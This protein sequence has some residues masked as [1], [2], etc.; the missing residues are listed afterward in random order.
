MTDILRKEVMPGNELWQLLMLLAMV[1]VAMVAGQLARFFI[2]RA[3]ARRKTESGRWMLVLLRSL[4]RAIILICF[5]VGL[6]MGFAY[7]TVTPSIRSVIDTVL[8][9]LGTIAVGYLIYCLVDLVD[10]FLV[11]WTAKTG[12]KVDSMLLPLVGKSVRI[13]IV[14]L[15][16]VQ[17]L[18]SISDKPITSILAGLGVGGLALALAGQETLKNVIGSLVIVADKP[19]EIGDRIKVGEFDGPV[20]SVG[21]RSTR[22]RTI[23]G[24]LVTIPNS[25]M[26]NRV[27]ENIGKRT[28]VRHEANITVTYDT[29]PQKME[30]ALGI[31]REILK[32]HEGMRQSDPPQVHFDR[33]CDWALNIQMIYWYCTTDYWKY[34]DFAERVNMEI[35]RKFTDAGISF[36]FPTQTLHVS[37]RS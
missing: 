28:H 25:D 4:E 35:L 16:A 30:Q 14:A 37:S 29:S 10:H 20:E 34:L 33:F 6:W 24:N 21:F 2:E 13:T 27:I 8:R 31:V 5:A 15:I 32:D 23:T 11:R 36:A 26:V 3:G 18:D 9:V 22:M 1:F 12:S 17:I 19:F 7:L